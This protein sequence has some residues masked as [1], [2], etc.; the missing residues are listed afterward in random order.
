MEKH[1]IY[2]TVENYGWKSQVDSEYSFH[3]FLLIGKRF[4]ERQKRVWQQWKVDI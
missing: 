2:Y 1:K 3:P 4:V